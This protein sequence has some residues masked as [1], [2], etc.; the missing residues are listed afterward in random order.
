MKRHLSASLSSPT[1]LQT[2]SPCSLAL[3][4]QPPRESVL[5]S[6]TKVVRSEPGALHSVKK[7]VPGSP[8]GGKIHSNDV[9]KLP[10]K[11]S[12]AS[13]ASD[14]K[15]PGIKKELFSP[16]KLSSIK[17]GSASPSKPSALKEHTKRPYKVSSYAEQMSNFK[18]SSLQSKHPNKVSSLQS[19][20]P[21]MVICLQS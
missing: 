1:K 4:R 21:Y 2:T 5:K 11:E 3:K 17:N 7:E 13:P 9:H 14:G 10:K 12:F 15:R 20:H 16:T 8:F 6:P 19:K 18:L